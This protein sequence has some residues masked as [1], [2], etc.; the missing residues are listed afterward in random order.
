MRTLPRCRVSRTLATQA[1]TSPDAAAFAGLADQLEEVLA[2][3]SPE[4]TKELL[5]LLI[6]EIRVHDRRRIVPDLQD[7]AAA[8]RAMPSKVGRTERCAN[9][10]RI[11]GEVIA[12][13]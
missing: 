2:N 6:K 7:P 1:H 8:V 4:Q 5:R 12:V 13:E 3:E 10:A 9:H 11:E